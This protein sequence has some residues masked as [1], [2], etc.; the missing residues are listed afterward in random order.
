[1]KPFN[2]LADRGAK[3]IYPSARSRKS[4]A[5]QALDPR[6]APRRIASHATKKLH[7]GEPICMKYKN[8]EL[9]LSVLPSSL[10]HIVECTIHLLQLRKVTI[11]HLDPDLLRRLFTFSNIN[12]LAVYIYIEASTYLPGLYCHSHTYFKQHK[13]LQRHTIPYS[14]IL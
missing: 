4:K 2:V 9:S 8:G 13:E 6:P 3:E 10:L 14:S 12:L 7:G 11:L 5:W 1:M